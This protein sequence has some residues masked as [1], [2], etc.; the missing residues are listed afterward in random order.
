MAGPFD[1]VMSNRGT[2]S[3]P[4]TNQFSERWGV[5]PGYIVTLTVTGDDTVGDGYFSVSTSLDES[6]GISLG[7]QWD[8][9]YANVMS[10]A[11]DAAQSKGGRAG[12]AIGVARQIGGAAG[13]SG[14]NPATT[15]QVWQSSDPIAFSIPFTFIAQSDAKKEVQDK[16]VNLL[17]LTAPS[18]KGM[19]LQAP[20]P[21]I[22]G[23]LSQ[24][25]DLKGRRIVLRVGKFMELD[26]CIVERVDVQ[27]D[28]IIGEQG[29]PH[30]AK[31]TVD[32]KSFF[33][34]FTVQDIDKLFVI[35]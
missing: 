27:F 19:I 16:V 34:C 33:T 18:E 29:I 13:L 6:F 10:D 22:M 24:K 5:D 7:S 28:S 21:T 3:P 1:S 8:A 23:Q 30:K 11:M 14:R 15:A 4:S 20:G 12:A 35:K 31:V 17:K 32:I 9:P 26:N 2:A 25:S